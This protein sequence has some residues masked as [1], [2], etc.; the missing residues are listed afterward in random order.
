MQA[1]FLEFAVPNQHRVPGLELD[2][3]WESWTEAETGETRPLAEVMDEL[4]IADAV[5]LQ[6]GCSQPGPAMSPLSERAFAYS[7]SVD[8]HG[9]YRRASSG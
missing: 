8:V 5:A 4:R 1:F 2:R 3:L 9:P 6:S 7:P